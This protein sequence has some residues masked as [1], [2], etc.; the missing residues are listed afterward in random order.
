MLHQ[1][2]FKNFKS[3]KEETTLDLLAASIKEHETDVVTDIMSEKVLKIA[4]IYG[5]NASGKSNVIEAFQC[6]RYLV[7]NSFN[8]T[9]WTQVLPEPNWFEDERVPTEFDVLFSA[10]Q[11]IYQYGFS[12]LKGRVVEEYLYVRDHKQKKE[13]YHQ[14]V[15]RDKDGFSGM[16]LDEIGKDSI[17]TLV[18]EHTLFISVLS[19]FKIKAIHDVVQWF[20]NS[21]VSDY[22]NPQKERVQYLI[23]DNNYTL[24]ENPLVQIIEN[25]REKERLEKFLKAIDVGIY[26]IDVIK[27]D[28]S[29]SIFE[30]DTIEKKIVT[31]HKNPKTNQLVTASLDSESSG[32]KKMLM[33]YV[34]L[35]RIMA[36]GGVIF[37]DEMDAKLHPLLIRYILIMFH[38]TKI[39]VN[40]AQLVFSTQ[41]VFTLDKD[42]LR[43]DEIWFVDKNQYGE[44]QLYSLVD[45]VDDHNKKVRNDASYG[46][47]YILGRYK[48]I[49]H[50][51]RMEGLHA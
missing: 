35:K 24:S 29:N 18:D 22:G 42:N 44:S 34:E 39:N 46:K 15:S 2:T 1:F 23:M 33:L 5:A 6:M 49:P 7:L 43:R 10:N 31:Y 25:Q 45:Y 11:R 41:E 28:F 17:L 27:S 50:L 4:A 48:S 40:H 47:D 8:G 14:L 51:Q 32:T 20:E 16:L 12:L 36:V 13:K 21:I 19:K 26:G 30:N 37:I 38:D 3:F 9:H